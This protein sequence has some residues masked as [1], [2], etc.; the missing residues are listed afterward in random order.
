MSLPY[1]DRHKGGAFLADMEKFKQAGMENENFYGWG[2]ED[3][4][5]YERWRNLNYSIFFASGCMYHL[6]H[7]RDMNGMYNSRRQMQITQSELAKTKKSSM[8]DLMYSMK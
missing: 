2:P 3:Y 1:G 7:P 8:E 4:E 6:T 5:R